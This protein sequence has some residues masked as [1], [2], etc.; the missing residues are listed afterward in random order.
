[1]TLVEIIIL[2]IVQGLTEFLPVSSSGHLVVTNAML[3]S[4]GSEPVQDLVA[5]NVVLH[6]GTLVAVLAY[7]RREIVQLLVR[8]RRV[9]PLLVWG[10][11]PAAAIGIGIKKG[12][13]ETVET[14][15]LEN[16]MVAGL[17]FPVTA[18]ALVWSSRSQTGKL[19]YQQL[20]Y[21]QT[22]IIGAVQAFALLPGI[23]RSGTTIAAGLGVGMQRSAAATFA[24][25][26]AI[27]AI[28]GAGALEGLQ[29]IEDYR[30]G[31][32][33]E[34]RLSILA[35]GFLVSMIVGYA[36]LA[37]LIRFV[38]QGRLAMFAY[39]L[40]PLGIAVVAWQLTA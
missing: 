11:I 14:A 25:L 34:T 37:L 26:L 38:Q 8:D 1:M 9:I 40:V 24:F 35:V 23:S 39:Y 15:V 28:G 33:A 12:L 19:E 36:S 27:P 17:M 13:P 16:P 20:N 7:Y 32:A 31:A 2:G 22:L 3:E 21:K 6:V 18:A 5:V 29:M 10:T 30:S 4:W